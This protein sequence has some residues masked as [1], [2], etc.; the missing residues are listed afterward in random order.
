MPSLVRPFWYCG[1][2]SFFPFFFL[3]RPKGMRAAKVAKSASRLF[4]AFLSCW[5]PKPTKKALV[6]QFV[7][8]MRS[9]IIGTLSTKKKRGDEPGAARQLVRLL[10]PLGKQAG[11]KPKASALPFSARRVVFFF[12][13]VFFSHRCAACCAHCRRTMQ[14]RREILPLPSKKKEKAT[15]TFFYICKEGRFCK[16]VARIATAKLV[17]YLFFSRPQFPVHAGVAWAFLCSGGVCVA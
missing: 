14:K 7:L 6:L 15:N 5:C 10:F 8:K 3:S 17:A 4:L 13:R 9:D 16:R 11:T 2:F 12:F 1:S